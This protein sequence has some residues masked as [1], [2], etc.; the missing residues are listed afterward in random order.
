MVTS[1]TQ[2]S[3]TWEPTSHLRT[4]EIDTGRLAMRAAAEHF[5]SIATHACA[6]L[7]ESPEA[8]PA[9]G[10]ML[11]LIETGVGGQDLES[12]DDTIIARFAERFDMEPK[13]AAPLLSLL[14]AALANRLPWQSV[15]EVCDRLLSES[16][17]NDL[18]RSI[19]RL[20]DVALNSMG[21]GSAWGRYFCGW[22]PWLIEQWKAFLL[23]GS[24]A[25]PSAGARPVRPVR[26]LPDGHDAPAQGPSLDFT[27]CGKTG[28]LLG[29]LY[30]TTLVHSGAPERLA[31]WHRTSRPAFD[32]DPA[33][34]DDLLEIGSLPVPA[35]S[36][37]VTILERLTQTASL[38]FDEIVTGAAGVPGRMHDALARL[39]SFSSLG[40]PLAD[41]AYL[42]AIPPIVIARAGEARPA[43]GLPDMR[44]SPEMQSLIDTANAWRHRAATHRELH[45]SFLPLLSFFPPPSERELLDR[46]LENATEFADQTLSQLRLRQHRPLNDGRRTK[47]VTYWTLP[48]AAGQIRAG[49]LNIT[50]PAHGDSFDVC[51][52]TAA[53]A[54]YETPT[55]MAAARFDEI[56]GKW[57]ITC[58]ER[59]TRMWQAPPALMTA[60]GASLTE[61]LSN[62]LAISDLTVAYN[63]GLI[64]SKAFYLGN[65]ALS[66]LSFSNDPSGALFVAHRLTLTI[67]ADG[68]DHEAT[69]AGTCVIGEPSGNGATLLYLQGDTAA[70]RAYASPRALLD[71]IE[72]DHLGVR[73]T[74]C[75][76]LPL[77]MRRLAANGT[78]TATLVREDKRQPIQIASQATLATLSADGTLAAADR[79][80]AAR[81]DQ[82]R[83]WLSGAGTVETEQGVH[84]YRQRCMRAG[85]TLPGQPISVSLSDLRKLAHVETLRLRL[86]AAIPN[87]P[88][89]TRTHLVSRLTQAGLAPSDPDRIYVKTA[90]R[91]AQSLSDLVIRE[92]VL[93]Q[94]LQDLPLL[95]QDALGKFNFVRGKHSATGHGVLLRDVLDKT[96][97]NAL[98]Q[99]I[100]NARTQ[101][102][103]TSRGNVR[104]VLKSEF[105]AQ[106]WL[107]RA[108]RK[109]PVEQVHIAA[110]VAGPIELARLS[111]EELAREIGSP[112]VEREWLC[113][114][115]MTTTLMQVSVAGRPACLLIAPFAEGLRVIGFDSRAQL[116]DWFDAQMRN[117][118]TRARITSTLRDTPPSDPMWHESARL[119]AQGQRDT[120]LPDTFTAVASAYEMRQHQHRSGAAD[121]NASRPLLDL[122]GMFSKVDLALGV[123]TW[124][125]PFAR[126]ISFVYSTA[127]LTIGTAGMGVGLLTNDQAVF[128]QS[129]QSVL[130]AIGAQGL[131]AVRF[132]AW[133]W[134][135]RD[136]RFRYFVSEAPRAQE[137]LILGLHRVGGRFY[138]GIDSETR[139]Y[140]RLD[141]A[142]GFFRME[143]RALAESAKA[144]A[145]FLRLSPSGEWHV[146]TQ[147]DHA[148][149][150]FDD[151][152]VAWRID[153]GF[154][155]R[156]DALRD[157]R[158]PVFERARKAVTSVASPGDGMPLTWHLRLRKLDFLDV[159]ITDPETLGTLAGRVDFLQNGA[160]ASALIVPSPLADDAA[161]LGAVFLGITQRARTYLANVRTGL[162]RGCTL[163]P[164]QYPVEGMIGVYNTLARGVTTV[165]ARFMS[166]LGQLGSMT[167]RYLSPPSLAMGVQT[168]D[169]LFEGEQTTPRAYEMTAGVRTL[170]LGRRFLTVG[171]AQ[172]YFFDPEFGIVVH[173]DYAS[174]LHMLRSHLN[175][176]SR[177][178][179]LVSQG[180]T[181]AVDTREIDIVRLGEAE[182]LRD[183]NELVPVR[184][185][186]YL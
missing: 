40:L 80:T 7:D 109:M 25:C 150:T 142:T 52:R 17:S 55:I 154:R 53:G 5:G 67:A 1:A 119:D 21:Y 146:V 45:A 87:V 124:F 132:K 99:Q 79:D 81:I 34:R 156:Y 179:A 18:R 95:T 10:L 166:D 24:G 137:Q 13:L 91:Q 97:M 140:V 66:N 42:P 64:S 65:A 3:T 117:Q 108:Q 107:D 94:E 86:S 164:P 105:I 123:A 8:G 157:K 155:A 57:R 181:L 16:T 74:L 110:R 165:S 141:P 48:E 35:D 44:A 171:P 75:E 15:Q 145:P 6:L 83:A 63:N 90:R 61:V 168:L 38:A 72:G 102:W 125:M 139:A 120:T 160:D 27:H 51:T 180:R 144:D 130:S 26:F 116:S 50:A 2:T 169:T 115:G 47:L 39:L 30:G 9:L 98:R 174:V 159:T 131:A 68:R 96:S 111:T 128:Q 127:D 175:A 92:S 84:Q 163:V 60:L 158:N 12:L 14:P 122:M 58:E 138:A 37:E 23:L 73:T 89:L 43:S 71:D 135:T 151:P 29:L 88:E 103:N 152:H 33:L 59:A 133:L 69:P 118:T 162:L 28:Y 104:K 184:D 54:I 161:R 85:T 170:L 178:Y 149:P 167:I 11:A 20:T 126:P 49:R 186:L 93:A 121:T 134:V 176:M 129:W 46:L 62:A 148:P 177:V 183:L 113:V 106:V 114:G 101:F 32:P 56:V 77:S 31:G 112:A 147:A 76:R 19:G 136:P 185:A 100:D 143:R 182:L 41:A 70:W 173:H 4:A 22:R 172:Y 78:S 82:Y 36:P 153:E